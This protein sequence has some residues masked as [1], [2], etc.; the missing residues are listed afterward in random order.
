MLRRMTLQ[1][2]TTAITTAT[3]STTAATR[4]T[5]GTMATTKSTSPLWPGNGQD[6][7]PRGD[8]MKQIA[9][10]ALGMAAKKRVLGRAK[11]GQRVGI[12]RPPAQFRKQLRHPPAPV[13][14][15]EI[16]VSGQSVAS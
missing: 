1:L 4:A 11:P 15:F 8:W 2:T 10:W 12:R 9:D 5:A 3:A 16:H 13:D 6:G 14:Q 7:A